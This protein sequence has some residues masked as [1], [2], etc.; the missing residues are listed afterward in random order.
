MKQKV[1]VGKKP[2]H[3]NYWQH[4]TT[5]N[6]YDLMPA[7]SKKDNQKTVHKTWSFIERVEHLWHWGKK[8]TGICL[9][10][11]HSQKGMV[12]KCSRCGNVNVKVLNESVR[13]PSK[14]RSKNTWKNFL[15][16]FIFN[17]PGT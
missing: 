11:Y 7:P 15:N 6:I 13:V 3:S 9:T 16:N 14:K 4:R 2:R 12:S 10:C 1:N 5:K 8:T 17:K